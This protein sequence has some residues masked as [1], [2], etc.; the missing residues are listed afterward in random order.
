MTKTTRLIN[1]DDNFISAIDYAKK[2]FYEGEV[3]AYP[4]DT[5]YGL[6][7]NP[8][9]QQAVE[10]IGVIKQR[11]IGSQYTMLVASVDILQKYITLADERHFDFLLSIWANPISVVLR[12]NKETENL[13]GMKTGTF[14]IPNNK[15]C[16]KLLSETKMPLVSTSVNRRDEMPLN[17]SVM[18]QQEFMNELDSIFYS[19]KK[20]LNVSS[21]LID[22]TDHAPKLLRAGKIRFEEI[23]TRFSQR[24][25]S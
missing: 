24:Q 13:L 22:L 23:M 1:I 7:A 20:S 6:G 8:F 3:F 4:T 15:F 12:L 14:R 17:D 11:E 10:N 25:N 2:I 16:I 19:H 5:I 18:I 9:N 21:T